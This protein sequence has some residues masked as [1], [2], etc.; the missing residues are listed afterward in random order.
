MV[1]RLLMPPAA[2]VLDPPAEK[3]TDAE[4]ALLLEWIEQGAK[5]VGGTECE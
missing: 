5:P 4:R 2:P 1:D 3:L